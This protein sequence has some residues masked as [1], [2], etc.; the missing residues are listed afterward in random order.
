[1]N[2]ASGQNLFG[3]PIAA[4]SVRILDRIAPGSYTMEWGE[5][6]ADGVTYRPDQGTVAV[7]LA[8]SLTPYE[9]AALYSPAP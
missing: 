5:V 7:T 8:P 4:D 1:M 6:S 3:S 2:F 9:F